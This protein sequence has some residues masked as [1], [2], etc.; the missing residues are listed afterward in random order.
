MHA[1]IILLA[2]L[3]SWVLFWKMWGGYYVSPTRVNP[4]PMMLAYQTIASLSSIG[5][6]AIRNSRFA[7]RLVPQNEGLGQIDKRKFGYRG[8][9]VAAY[10]MSAVFIVVPLAVYLWKGE[11]DMRAMAGKDPVCQDQ[12]QSMSIEV[13]AHTCL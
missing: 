3:M 1:L 9:L 12:V 7:Q 4:F 10:A 11:I 2:N 6:F 8:C 13:R 5:F